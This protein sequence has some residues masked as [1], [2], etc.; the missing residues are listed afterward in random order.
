MQLEAVRYQGLDTAGHYYLSYAQPRAFGDVSDKERQQLRR[1]ARSRL[2]RHRQRDRRRHRAPVAGRSAAG[3]VGLR[4]AAGRP[5]QAPGGTRAARPRRQRHARKRPGRLHAG[6]RDAGRARAASSAARSSTSRRRFCIFSAS[7]SAATWTAT[8]AP[9]CSRAPSPPSARSR[10]FRHMG[11]NMVSDDFITKVTK[12]RSH[13]ARL[14]SSC[15]RD[16]CA[17][18]SARSLSTTGGFR[19]C[20]TDCCC[21]LAFAGL[22]Q[23]PPGL[24]D[25]AFKVPAAGEAVAVIHASCERCD[26]G[27]EGREAAAVKILVDGKY[28][29]HLL[30][31][32]GADEADYHVTLG[33]DRGRATTGCA[34]RPIRRCRRRRPVPPRLPRSTSS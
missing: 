26:W 13:E 10:S 6:L 27:V 8:R 28:S 34:S 2:R 4:H 24:V 30:L 19:C 29:Q 25:Q 11:D 9:T 20:A 22:L 33:P 17:E 21:R 18:P 14:V 32:R 3:G 1:R 12:A 15:L 31:A 7:R 16:L 23:V 5:D